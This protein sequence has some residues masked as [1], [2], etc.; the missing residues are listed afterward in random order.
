MPDPTPEQRELQEALRLY[1]IAYR[2]HARLCKLCEGLPDAER[3][4]SECRVRVIAALDAT[5]E[6]EQT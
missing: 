6:K 5:A 3:D 2:R 4:L 1:R